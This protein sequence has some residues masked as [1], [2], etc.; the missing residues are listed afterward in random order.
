MQALQS[1]YLTRFKPYHL[2]TIIAEREMPK[3]EQ[4]KNVFLSSFSPA[5]KG[6]TPQLREKMYS[7]YLR[8]PHCVSSKKIVEKIQG[9]CL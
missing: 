5:L 9:G 4:E 1:Q 2:M 3:K 8:R 7:P 6:F